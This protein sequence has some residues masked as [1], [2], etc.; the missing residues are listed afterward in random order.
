MVPASSRR[1][2]R[3]A[4]YPTPAIR[5]VLVLISVD[6]SIESSSSLE[7]LAQL[8][9]FAFAADGFVDVAC[10]EDSQ[11]DGEYNQIHDHA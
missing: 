3:P 10:E 6:Q 7:L 5:D 1:S 11:S 2:D 4:Y 8:L 9:L